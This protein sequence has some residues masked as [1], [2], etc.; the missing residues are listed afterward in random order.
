MRPG[1]AVPALLLVLVSCTR[2]NG[3]DIGPELQPLPGG[4]YKVLVRDDQGNPVVEAL[5]SI[6]GV[7]ETATTGHTGRAMVNAAVSGTSVITVDGTNAAATDTDELGT[8]HISVDAS[9]QTELPFTMFLPD[10]SG[11][12]GLTMT[13]GT[14]SAPQTLADSGTGS[15]AELVISSGDTVSFG[16]ASSVTVKSGPLAE[17]HL[18]GIIP[19]QVFTGRGVFISPVGVQFAMGA[20][21]SL[22]N[23]LALG[24]SATADL[25][26][27]DPATGIWTNVGS[28]TESGG[29]IVAPA[30][31]VQSGGLYCF[32]AA[33]GSSSVVSGQVVDKMSL[34]LPG[35]LVRGPQATTRTDGLG[36]Y[37]LPAMASLDASNNTRTV[38]VEFDGGRDY[39]PVRTTSS[40]T[41][42]AATKTVNVSLDT[43]P[44]RSLRVLM[45]YHGVRHPLQPINM[46]GEAGLNIGVANGN[47][48][49][50]ASHD[51]LPTGYVG[52]ET[53]RPKDSQVIVRT[54]Q[55]FEL[56]GGS[57][58]FDVR[59]FGEDAAWLTGG[60][61]ST[62]TRVVDEV[63]TGPIEQADVIVGLNPGF[64]LED[65]TNEFGYTAAD[66]GKLGQVT[67]VFESNS[68]GR[69]VVSAITMVSVNTGD[70]SLP[71]ARALRRGLGAFQRYGMF[72]GNLTNTVGSN[73][74]R[75]RATGT[76][77]LQDFY[78][79]TFLGQPTATQTPSKVDPAVTG[80]TTYLFGVP[81]GI[82]HLAATEG[83]T[84][85]GVFTLERVGL[86]LD[87]ASVEGT[88]EAQDLDLS[89]VANASF[90]VT[91]AL[92]DKDASIPTNVLRFALAGELPRTTIVDIDAGIGGN[93]T[94][95]G[96]DLIFTLPPV[97]SSLKSYVLGLSGSAVTSGRTI[98]QQTFIRLDGVNTPT[99]PM[100]PA[101]TV[102][103]PTPGGTISSAGFT[104][105]LSSPANTMYTMLEL[106]TNDDP[107]DVRKWTVLLPG[108]A[109]SFPFVMW[110][111]GVPSLLVSGRTWT[112]TATSVR[113][114]NGPM[115]DPIY[116]PIDSYVRIL[117][118]WVGIGES[119][120]EVA[121]FA[122]NS[123]TVTSN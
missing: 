91:N 71:L 18:P 11:S 25:Y 54:R 51:D 26:H 100:H 12:T 78:N 6:S 118:N 52:F 43:V 98:T 32:V 58:T 24:A 93:M 15:G 88:R 14:Q 110:P 72:T 45:I 102:T 99:V 38:T 42:D 59:V 47:E 64:G 95:S 10:V 120:R 106:S 79:Q 84:T 57:S 111:A 94:V 114:D 104:V 53:A 1:W 35:V 31:S 107:D 7:T 113:I 36:R 82:G 90:T 67:A 40:V 9:G 46:S 8:L 69:T 86:A 2:G 109:T 62:L 103:S 30:G 80:G 83:T 60:G 115:A 44:V 55:V 49:A 65:P 28:G 101:P 61:N 92:V 37:T 74:K 13:T 5:V 121:A 4:D 19:M 29:R 75:V 66:I 56:K 21:L 3:S 87:L 39:L 77:T 81:A 34:P 17:G 97:P 27:L 117:A 85:G 68:D 122:S 16:T 96:N 105:T 41:L 112:F 89:L 50:Q 70:I 63:G 48:I 23:D 20:S 76:M 123:F 33:S 73:T 119:E 22:P 116:A 108:D